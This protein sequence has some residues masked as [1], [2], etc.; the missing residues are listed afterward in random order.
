MHSNILDQFLDKIIP[1]YTVDFSLANPL[2][3]KI[4]FLTKAIISEKERLSKEKEFLFGAPFYIKSFFFQTYEI[5]NGVQISADSITKVFNFLKRLEYSLESSSNIILM[6]RSFLDNAKIEISDNSDYFIKELF[7]LLSLEQYGYDN[8]MIDNLIL[9]I[10]FQRITISDKYKFIDDI[11]AL[12]KNTHDKTVARDNLIYFFG[13]LFVKLNIEL[14]NEFLDKF[15]MRLYECRLM[16]DVSIFVVCRCFRL[17]EFY[18]KQK[19]KQKFSDYCVEKILSFLLKQAKK[20][21]LYKEPKK[22]LLYKEEN[23]TIPYNICA[24]IHSDI[25]Y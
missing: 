16:N 24:Y 7:G 22:D 15:F 20:D 12:I 11:F 19:V 5:P 25:I 13:K 8:D 17:M 18:I 10:D 4:S 3:H 1:K 23:E 14:S 21:L 2:G 9:M 6:L